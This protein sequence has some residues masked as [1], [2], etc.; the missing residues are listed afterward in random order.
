MPKIL[1]SV[2]IPV[3]NSE[4][5]VSETVRRART[6]FLSKKLD[7]EIVL[8]DDG[9]ADNSWEVIRE[10]AL[11]FPEVI[12]VHL[13][14]NYGQ[15]NANLCGFR[16][17]K[18]DY[19]ITMD[20]DLQNPPEEIDKLI[21]M[22][23]KGFDLVIG[24][25]ENK[26]HSFV[27]RIGSKL[28][29][30]LIRRVFDVKD[31]LILSNFRIIRRDVID[32]ICNENS[33]NPYIPGLVLRYS[34]QRGNVLVR[35]QDRAGGK[36]GYTWQKLLHLVASILFNYS[37]IP[38]RYCAAFG[39]TT[40]AVSFFLSFFFMLRAFISGTAAPGWPS[41]IVL[42]SF[43]NG[44]LILLTSIIGEYLI[45]ILRELNSQRSYIISEVVR[46]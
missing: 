1:Y 36:S 22:S 5:I 6:F 2:V 23:T 46:Q 39:F 38:L 34:Q 32:R 24:R 30:A 28:V 3:Y 9:S 44:V 26:K 4:N 31:N 15:H 18:G 29:G 8:V 41:L 7:Y 43:F 13:L 11:Q 12:A 42:M 33:V 16:E 21:E 37:T 27:R 25:F 10:L 20:D 40:A 14:K 35:H 19:I 17:A 45:R